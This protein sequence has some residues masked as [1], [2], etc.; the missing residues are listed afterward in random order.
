MQIIAHIH[1]EFPTKFGVPR[2]SGLAGGLRGTIV[3]TPPYR[4]PDALRGIEGFSHIWLIWQFH[5]AL[6]EGFSPTVLPPKLGGKTRVGVFAT[7]SPFRPN[8]IGLSSVRLLDVELHTPDGPV[9]HV[10]G[11][12]LVDGTPIFDIKPYLPYADCH[13]DATDAFAETRRDAPLQVVFP[14]EWLCM[15][16]AGKRE[17][18]F[19]VL[20]LDTRPGYQHD[21]GRRY[22]FNYAGFDVRFTIDND[23][24]TV[25][26]VVKL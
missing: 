22:G 20:A 5:K 13:M 21:P 8:A 26:E 25:V 18:L 17:A 23:T 15:I 14:D 12:D 4:N 7:R 24:L 2:Q 1:T 11:A 10:A 3:F 6:R 9:L 16:P 19:E